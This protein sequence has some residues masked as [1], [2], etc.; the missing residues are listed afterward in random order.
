MQDNQS[1]IKVKHSNDCKRVFGRYDMNC[2]RCVELSQGAPARAGWSDFRR[3]Q[4]AI[5]ERAIAAHFAP[6]GR[7][8]QLK[9]KGLEFT[10]TAF[11]W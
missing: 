7:Y 1:N 11:E 3:Q 8:D 4:D 10:D 2:P 6:G 9:A 5:R